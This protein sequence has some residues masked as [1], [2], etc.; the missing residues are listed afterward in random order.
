[1]TEKIASKTLRRA[2]LQGCCHCN[3]IWHYQNLSAFLEHPE[4]V[5]I[6]KVE[7]DKDFVRGLEDRPEYVSPMRSPKW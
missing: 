6:E 4:T 3:F 1:L 5:P 2:S 7:I